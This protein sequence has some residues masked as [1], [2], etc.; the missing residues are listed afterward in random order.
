M[1]AIR[2]GT[3][4]I[5]HDNTLDWQLLEGHQPLPAERA[6]AIAR[7]QLVTEVVTVDS[8]VD[9]ALV[10]GLGTDTLSWR[11]GQVPA[12]ADRAGETLAARLVVYAPDW[13]SGLVW[14]DG[15]QV[16]VR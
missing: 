10:T 14:A 11:L 8:A 13:P 12:F 16:A 7:A 4:F 9:P 1:P 3:V 2:G 6:L 15:I 5:G